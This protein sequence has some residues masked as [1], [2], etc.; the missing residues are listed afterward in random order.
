MIKQLIT[1]SAVLISTNAHCQYNLQ[2]IDANIPL[3]V[4]NDYAVP[5]SV[6]ITFTNENKKTD[7]F[8]RLAGFD[9]HNS[10]N[11]LYLAKDKDYYSMD[12]KHLYRLPQGDSVRTHSFDSRNAGI[13]IQAGIRRDFTIVGLSLYTSAN[14]GLFAHFRQHSLSTYYTINSPDTVFYQD[15]Y[16]NIIN[17]YTLGSAENYA[18]DRGWSI[19]PQVGIE[20]GIILQ[21]HKRCSVIPKVIIQTSAVRQSDIPQL[22]WGFSTQPV[23]R[24][25]YSVEVNI[26]LGL[27]VSYSV[28]N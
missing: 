1:F 26:S 8:V 13:G 18:N 21:A 27:Q 20:T 2:S 22:Y 7:L 15:E 16:Y 5:Y 28:N 11:A 4:Q 12:V 3:L 9:Y 23:D 25:K 10:E 14:L 19:L 17:D 24:T 6:G